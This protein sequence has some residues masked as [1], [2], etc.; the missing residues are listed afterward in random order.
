MKICVFG[1][2]RFGTQL[3]IKLTENG[4]DVIAIDKD[5]DT[6]EEIK[7]KVSQALVIHSIDERTL[8]DLGIDEVKTVVIA[9]GRHFA[10]SVLLTRIL[11]KKLEIPTVI[12]RSTGELRGEVLKLVGAD[13]VVLPEL[14]AAALLADNLSSPFPHLNRIIDDFCTG[15]MIAPENFVGK[16]LNEIKLIENYNVCAI[17]IKR[18]EKMLL[19]KSDLT[20]VDGD[21]MYFSGNSHD[22]NDLTKMTYSHR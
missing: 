15:Q 22:L 14:E 19:P 10:E 20:I 3:A 8:R 9:L 2:G 21:I 16:T 17:G 11:K 5:E 4:I 6:I 1:I 13:Q 18:D 7:D 12:V